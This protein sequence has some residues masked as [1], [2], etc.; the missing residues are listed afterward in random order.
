MASQILVEVDLARLQAFHG[1]PTVAGEAAVALL[2]AAA[3]RRVGHWRRAV[4]RGAATG[5]RGRRVGFVGP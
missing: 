2:P 3:A 1:A 4:R 5:G